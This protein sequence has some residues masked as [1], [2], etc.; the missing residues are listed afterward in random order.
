MS[1]YKTNLAIAFAAILLS[2]SALAGGGGGGNGG[3][4]NGGGGDS[5]DPVEAAASQT[6]ST[7]DIRD[8]FTYDERN[9]IDVKAN[10]VVA[11]SDLKGAVR[12]NDANVNGNF[13]SSQDKPSKDKDVPPTGSAAGALNVTTS[14]SINGMSHIAGI[15]TVAQNAGA[16]SLVQQSVNTNASLHSN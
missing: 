3:G 11:N 13:G 7:L 9:S 12:G 2:G 10:V 4:G 5:E 14:N 6:T 16:N 1:L 15:T 8:S